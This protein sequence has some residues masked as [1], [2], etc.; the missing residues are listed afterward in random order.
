LGA[1][2]EG[3]LDLIKKLKNRILGL[4]AI[5]KSRA[6]QKSQITWLRKGDTTTKYFQIMANIRKQRNFIHSLQTAGALAT[7]QQE[8]HNVIYSHFLQH[9]GSHIPR[10]CLI[11]LNELGWQPRHLQ[12]LDLPF[13]EEEVANVIKSAP[14]EKAPDPD[15]FIGLF[16][17][18]CWSIIREDFM[19]AIDQFYLSNQQGINF[20]NQTLVVLI[21]KNNNP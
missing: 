2:S 21:P 15:G 16:F 14:K 8:K 4:A 12:H 13:T 11:N 19:R 5:E 7:T 9:I 10:T 18:L 20:L 1:L 3:E 6:R 17:S